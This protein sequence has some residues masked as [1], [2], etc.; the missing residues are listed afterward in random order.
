MEVTNSVKNQKFAITKVCAS[1]GK[2]CEIP[3]ILAEEDPFLCLYCY[4]E[5]RPRY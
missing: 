2:E 1:C 5:K 4:R 3:F